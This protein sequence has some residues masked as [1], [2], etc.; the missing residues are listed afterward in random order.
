VEDRIQ[1]NHFMYTL[2]TRLYELWFR[3]RS[4]KE[5]ENEK[6]KERNV[7]PMS[8]GWNAEDFSQSVRG[9]A[10]LISALLDLKDLERKDCTFDSLQ[11]EM[12]YC[13]I[14]NNWCRCS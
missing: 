3:R 9:N 4:K 2:F 14:T 1:R 12:T 10:A 11:R 6:Q 5:K 7:F 8:W 13:V